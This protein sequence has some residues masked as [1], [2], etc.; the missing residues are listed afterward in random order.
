MYRPD[1]ILMGVSGENEFLKD[2]AA[3]LVC[4]ESETVM[5][6]REKEKERD[7]TDADALYQK[8]QAYFEE[9]SEPEA[10]G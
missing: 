5:L 3:K 1:L 7:N 4:A 8:I 10:E 6:I 9:P 2:T